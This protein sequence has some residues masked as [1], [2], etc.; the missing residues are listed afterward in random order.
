[1]TSSSTPSKTTA[2]IECHFDFTPTENALDNRTILVTGA[3]DGI[4]REAALAYARYGATVILLGKTQEKLEQVYDAIEAQ[5]GAQPAIIP[6]NLETATEHDYQMIAEHVESTFGQL[7]GLLHN[8]SLLGNI[9]LL[10][11]YPVDTWM[12]VM[13]VN[14][15]AP[16]LLTR[17]LMPSLKKAPSASIILTSSSVGR[18][19]RAHWGAYAVSKFATEGMMQTLADELVNTTQIRVNSLNP[20]GTRTRMRAEAYPA[21]DP[22]TLRHPSEIMGTY[23][24]LM[25]D[26]SAGVTGHAFNAQ[27]P[28]SDK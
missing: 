8:A 13:Q 2:P 18:Q 1:M 25:S 15:N 14:I 26:S 27:P 22:T 23:L 4:G 19:G 24:Y 9:T 7:D 17:A 16:F 12:Q 28:K 6:L 21:E 3:G 11:Q 5:N 20:G 10:E